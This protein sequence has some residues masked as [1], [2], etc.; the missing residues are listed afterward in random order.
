[1]YKTREMSSVALCPLLSSVN[2]VNVL[3]HILDQLQLS[4][5]PST[6]PT[7]VCHNLLHG[8]LLQVTHFTIIT[9]ITSRVVRVI[10]GSLL[11]VTHFTIVTFITSHVVRVIDGSLLQVTHFTIITFITSRVVR[12]IDGSLLQVTHF[13]IITCITSRV[14]RVIG[15]VA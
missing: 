8:S 5:S 3:S 4:L 7:V 11:Q 10:D 15:I 14:V 12:V 2:V 13:T 1:V 6:S 9:F